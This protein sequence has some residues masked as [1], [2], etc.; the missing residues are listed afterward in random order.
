MAGSILGSSPRTAMTNDK[1]VEDRNLPLHDFLSRCGKV[2]PRAAIDLG[3]ELPLAGFGRPLE[4]EDIALD[5]GGVEIALH[6]PGRYD[7]S[8]G[9]LERAQLKK[10]AVDRDARL[11]LE[12]PLGSR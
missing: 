11:L 7:L 1:G 2:E 12:L 3:K 10:A 9:L 6:R 4:L 8:A 5:A